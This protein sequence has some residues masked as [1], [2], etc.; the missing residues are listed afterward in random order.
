MSGVRDTYH[1]GYANLAAAII[2][3]GVKNYDTRFLESDWCDTLKEMCTLDDIMYGGRNMPAC[4]R[5]MVS[6]NK[7]GTSVEF[8]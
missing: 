4:G 8:N 2:A 7:G 5:S 6:T 3:S 1:D